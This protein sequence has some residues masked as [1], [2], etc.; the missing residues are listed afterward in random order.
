[1]ELELR[2]D[3]RAP[4]PTDPK[5]PEPDADQATFTPPFASEG[6]ERV[7]DSHC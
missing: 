1:M 5:R 3:H 2:E 4:E 7:R 6:L